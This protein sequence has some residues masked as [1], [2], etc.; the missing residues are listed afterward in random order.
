MAV[1]GINYTGCNHNYD[2]KDERIDETNPDLRLRYKSIYLYFSGG[3]KIFRSGN[4][5]KDW[6]K[7]MKFCITQLNNEILS[8]SSS[9]DHFIMDGAKVDSAYLHF[10][11]NTPLLKYIDRTEDKWYLTEIPDGIE[12]FVEE[13]T[14]PTWEELKIV[15]CDIK[16]QK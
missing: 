16:K 1:L 13:G 5:I 15:C 6:Y 8:Q 4:F 3:K 11:N 14:T 2:D 10:E 12:F 7:A 9:V